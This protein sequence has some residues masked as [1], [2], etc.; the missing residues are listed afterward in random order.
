MSD[1]KCKNEKAFHDKVFDIIQTN[2]CAQKQLTTALRAKEGRLEGRF[3]TLIKIAL[4]WLPLVDVPN[5]SPDRVARKVWQFAAYHQKKGWLYAN[6]KQALMDFLNSFEGKIKLAKGNRYLQRH[7]R[8]IRSAYERIQNL[9]AKTNL[10]APPKDVP[11]QTHES[12]IHMEKETKASPQDV[13][14]T[15]ELI[16]HSEKAESG[17]KEEEY[18]FDIELLPITSILSEEKEE[19]SIVQKPELHLKDEDKQIVPKESEKK[20]STLVTNDK[21]KFSLLIV[22]SFKV[23]EMCYVLVYLIFGFFGFL[24]KGKKS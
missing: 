18:V 17:I 11:A 7:Q 4:S 15:P 23:V 19:I 24:I 6:D 5:T 10:S 14:E 3:V 12:P 13:E 1:I 8:S 21:K 20:N 22:S 9:P 16:I 2:Y